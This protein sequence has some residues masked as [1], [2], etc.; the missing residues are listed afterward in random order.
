MTTLPGSTASSMTSERDAFYESFWVTPEIPIPQMK[1]GVVV[2]APSSVT[3]ES[4]LNATTTDVR[5][6]V[7]VVLM[8]IEGCVELSN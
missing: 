2:M 1:A 5:L 4:V 7:L 3:S 8:T 6:K